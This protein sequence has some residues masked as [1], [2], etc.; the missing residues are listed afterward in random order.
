MPVQ[1]DVVEDDGTDCRADVDKRDRLH[2]QQDGVVLEMSHCVDIGL[3][4]G[5]RLH[6]NAVH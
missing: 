2:N 5:C 3:C 4:G 1:A 6:G